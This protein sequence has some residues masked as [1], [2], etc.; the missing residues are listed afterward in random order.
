[1]GSQA[2]SEKFSAYPFIT[3]KV[4]KVALNA[5]TIQWAQ[6]LASEGFVVIALN[7]GVGV[8]PHMKSLVLMEL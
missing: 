5:L 4:S 7:P 8:F 2:L 3:Y 6:A 1:M